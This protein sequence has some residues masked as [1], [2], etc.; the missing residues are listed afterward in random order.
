MKKIENMT[1]EEL[2]GLFKKVMKELAKRKTIK[3]IEIS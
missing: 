2:V 1:D 3:E